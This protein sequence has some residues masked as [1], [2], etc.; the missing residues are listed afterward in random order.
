MLGQAIGAVTDATHGM[1]LSAVS[2]PYYRLVM[3]YGVEKFAR[4]ARAVWDVDD[5]GRTEREVAEAGL[6]A[7]S[8]WMDQIGVVKHARELGLTEGNIP[9][10]VKATFILDGGYHRLEPQEVERIFR[11]SL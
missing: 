8:A 11:E 9:A 6:L 7:M 10:A 1:T 2:L 4:F 5:A 3:P